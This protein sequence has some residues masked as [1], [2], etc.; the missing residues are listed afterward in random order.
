MQFIVQ[1]S[2]VGEGKMNIYQLEGTKEFL[3]EKIW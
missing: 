3:M 1:S 2:L